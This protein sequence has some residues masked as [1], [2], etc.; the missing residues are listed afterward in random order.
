MPVVVTDE[1]LQLAASSIQPVA[2]TNRIA[3]IMERRTPSSARRY[4]SRLGVDL[5]ARRIMLPVEP[6]VGIDYERWCISLPRS[7]GN[8]YFWLLRDEGP[9]SAGPDVR[10]LT[11]RVFNEVE[12]MLP[13]D[14]PAETDE[15]AVLDV[16]LQGGR[17]ERDSVLRAA[18]LPPTCAALD[19]T[20]LRLARHATRPE[21]LNVTRDGLLRAKLRRVL[22]RGLALVGL[23]GGD[24]VVVTP[25]T[26]R[27]TVDDRLRELVSDSA[28]SAGV[29]TVG[30]A[31]AEPVEDARQRAAFLARVAA[32]PDSE[33]VVRWENAGAWTALYGTHRH[34]M[35]ADDVRPGLETLISERPQLAETARVYLESASVDE[36]AGRLFVHRTTLYYRLRQVE[37]VLLPGWDRG[38]QRAGVHAALQLARLDAG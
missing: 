12:T 1:S 4:V 31:S 33:P 9:C 36:A 18:G 17:E 6:G 11:D 20:V 14:D 10:A 23:A 5:H 37:K 26:D 3:T 8:L 28:L 13:P 29:S 30:D 24:L 27:R 22:S 15:Q 2:D 34:R 21:Q 25:S 19:V 35:R 32:L 7:S 38:W 16:L